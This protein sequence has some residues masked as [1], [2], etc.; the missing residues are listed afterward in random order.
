MKKIN[1]VY[2]F[3]VTK[4]PGGEE[5]TWVVDVK[6]GGGSVNYDPNGKSYSRTFECF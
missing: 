1:G 6:N 5:G 4:G 3:K 2:V